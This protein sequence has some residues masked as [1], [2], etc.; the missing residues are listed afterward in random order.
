MVGKVQQGEPA[1]A[2]DDGVE[3]LVDVGPQEDLAAGE[4]GPG[5]IGVLADEREHFVGGQLVGRLA[6]PDVAGLAAV[7]APVGQAEVQLERNAGR[8]AVDLISA[9]P[10]WDERRALSKIRKSSPIQQCPSRVR[11]HHTPGRSRAA[12]T[13]WERPR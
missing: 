1:P 8:V 5:D 6:L 7:L 2:G 11:P 3:D 13:V 4:V 12:S 9:P 10:R